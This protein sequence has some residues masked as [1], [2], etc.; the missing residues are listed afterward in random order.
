MSY[1]SDAAVAVLTYNVSYQAMS[2]NP[3]GTAGALGRK[4]VPVSPGNRLTICAQ[5][6][7]NAIDAMPGALGVDALDFVGI[8]EASRVDELQAAAEHSLRHMA[9]QRSRSGHSELASFYNPEVYA[10]YRFIPGEF[11][12]GRPFHILYCT[13]LDDGGGVIFINLHNAHG[14]SFAWIAGHLSAAHE[15]LDLKPQAEVL[16]D[17]ERSH[18]IIAI[19]DF[20]EAGWDWNAGQLAQKT[21]TPL[22]GAG[23]ETTVSIG[24]YP[25]SCCRSDGDWEAAGGGIARGARGGDYIFISAAPAETVVPSTYQPGLLQSDHLPVVARL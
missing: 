14:T 8:Q 16:S 10:C 20:N 21:W 5:N 7:A 13:R 19:G 12:Y 22:A 1:S 24:S 15:G 2:N 17:E 25:H 23:V 3:G 4:C 11:S 6:M 18:R 9:I